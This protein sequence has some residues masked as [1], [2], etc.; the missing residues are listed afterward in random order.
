MSEHR[1]D[2]K[3]RNY[4][5][6]TI[7]V[8]IILVAAALFIRLQAAAGSVGILQALSDAFLAAGGFLFGLWLLA[9]VWHK[10]GMD[11]PIYAAALTF[12]FAH[13]ESK[14]RE[15]LDFNEWRERKKQE[16]RE[17]VHLLHV[18]LAFLAA[19]ILMYVMYKV[20]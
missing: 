14:D 6:I 15:R 18:S 8:G 13:R 10:G 7:L 12:S 20:L 1:I 3:R 4:Y 19:A 9:I 11:L 16:R 5:M 17:P 2:R